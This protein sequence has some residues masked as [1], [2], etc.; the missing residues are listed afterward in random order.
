MTYLARPI[1]FHAPASR[2]VNSFV[3]RFALAMCLLS[4][5]AGAAAPDVME[6]LHGVENRY[7][8]IRTLE[9]SFQ[10]TYTAIRRGAKTESG[11][12]F[13]RKPGRM[14]WEYSTPAGKLFLS[15]GKYIYLFTPSANRVERSKVKE[16]DDMRAPLAFLL[17]RVDFHRD[18]KR[19]ILRQRGA[20]WTIT[21]EPRSDRAPFSQIEFQV[22]PAYEI[23]QLEVTGQDNSV[24]VFRFANE[25]QNPK[26]NEAMFR[27]TAP[28]GAEVVDEAQ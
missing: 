5:S 25:K 10:Q 4:T 23:R 22:G 14:R 8:S 18:F 2:I 6:T 19:F 1:P 21:A 9:V 11:Q 15:D 12:L 28:P 16:T 7:N 13:L 20:D 3:T 17:G 27:F 26:L 24:T